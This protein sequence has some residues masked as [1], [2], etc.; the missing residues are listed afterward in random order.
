VTLTTTASSRSKTL[1]KIDAATKKRNA[2]FEK[3]ALLRETCP[4][5]E[6]N[7]YTEEGN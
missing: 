1:A 7:F 6:E 2:W 3:L 4:E 5:K